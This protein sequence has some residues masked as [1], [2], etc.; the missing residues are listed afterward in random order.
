MS[1]SN[2]TYRSFT[3]PSPDE[4]NNKN[5]TRKSRRWS[6]GSHIGV[7][8]PPPGSADLPSVSVTSHLRLLAAVI[9]CSL[10]AKIFSRRKS[11]AVGESCCRLAAKEEWI[12]PAKSRKC[13]ET[14]NLQNTSRI[15]NTFTAPLQA[16]CMLLFPKE[17]SLRLHGS[18]QQS[19]RGSLLVLTHA[20]PGTIITGSAYSSPRKWK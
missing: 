16:L 7:Q 15:Q 20:R 8:L 12:S 3:T 18:S 1:C 4:N 5:R 14:L 17:H 11:I 10:A 19:C 6:V 13:S 9:R 2:P